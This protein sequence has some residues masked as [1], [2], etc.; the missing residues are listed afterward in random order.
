[1]ETARTRTFACQTVFDSE[2]ECVFA[3]RIIPLTGSFVNAHA[4]AAQRGG[5][6]MA[7]LASASAS[8]SACKVHASASPHY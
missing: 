3:I 1:M 2:E 5:S 4:N 6:G 8:A 7:R